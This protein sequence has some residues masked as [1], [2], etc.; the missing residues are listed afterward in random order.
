[1][2]TRV[3]MGFWDFS[4]EDNGDYGDNGFGSLFFTEDYGDNGFGGLLRT[5]VTIG[6][7]DFEDIIFFP[8]LKAI[9]FFN[10]IFTQYPR[11]YGVRQGDHYIKVY[12][13]AFMMR[14]TKKNVLL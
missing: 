8:G 12:P 10:F 13:F 5:M 1:M 7:M 14:E 4:S 9:Y 3:T 2:R 11:G 6:T